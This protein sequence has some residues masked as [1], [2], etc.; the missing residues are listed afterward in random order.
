MT[1]RI[2]PFIQPPSVAA[3]ANGKFNSHRFSATLPEA[4][5]LDPEILTQYVQTS[6]ENAADICLPVLSWL[7]DRVPHCSEGAWK[8]VSKEG[9]VVIYQSHLDFL[10]KRIGELVDFFD[11]A[12]HAQIRIRG[13]AEV[14]DPSHLSAAIVLTEKELKRRKAFMRTMKRSI[15]SAYLLGQPT[16]AVIKA[17]SADLR[18]R[19][20]LLAVDFATA[21]TN[22]PRNRVL[23][24]VTWTGPDTCR[25]FYWTAPIVHQTDADG[26]PFP[27]S[28][29]QRDR[30]SHRFGLV[31][32]DL[33]QATL[34]SEL[35]SPVAVPPSIRPLLAAIPEMLK[36]LVSYLD[37]KVIAHRTVEWDAFRSSHNSV[38]ERLLNDYLLKID[39]ALLIGPYVIAGWAPED[40]KSLPLTPYE[41]AAAAYRYVSNFIRITRR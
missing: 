33:M 40:V 28:V 12:L 30:F 14:E 13:Q 16:N 27:A 3:P 4:L 8:G 32:T 2:S 38:N 31:Q 36:P 35:P 23:G 24:L 11:A 15:V 25:Y 1:N 29:Y 20:A 19:V 34:S 26:R 37:G 39:P 6:V 21:L 18:A 22:G 17:F 7:E 10:R 5:K 41:V 9:A